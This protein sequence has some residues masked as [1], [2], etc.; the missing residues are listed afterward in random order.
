MSS[1]YRWVYTPNG[2]RL[3]SVGILADGSLHNPN[4]YPED[5]VRAA[6][7][8]ADARRHERR[9]QA[10]KQAAET[11]R[12]R[13]ARRVY[14]AVERIKAG[15]VYGPSGKCAICG[16]GLSDAESIQRGI[17]SDCWQAILALLNVA[18]AKRE[19]AP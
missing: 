11:R 18:Y 16:K 1:K 3:S 7:L 14:R 9:S 19:G 2:D 12:V 5:V 4:N 10:A 17:G 8:A 15:G 13:T 6:V